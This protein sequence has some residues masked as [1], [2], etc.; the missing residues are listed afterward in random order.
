MTTFDYRKGSKFSRH[1][2]GWIRQAMLRAMAEH[3][4]TIRIPANFT[5]SV[6]K[7]A[8][9]QRELDADLRNT[10]DLAAIARHAQMPLYR[11]EELGG[12]HS[13]AAFGGRAPGAGAGGG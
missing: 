5:E 1:A 4:R 10:S 11:V 2:R 6:R 3:G 8:R 7:I 13:G 9:A 12:G